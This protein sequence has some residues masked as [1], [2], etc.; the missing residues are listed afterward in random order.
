MSKIQP[1]SDSDQAAGAIVGG[2]LG[3]MAGKAIEE[4]ATTD[5]G[6]EFLVKL[7]NGAIKAFVEE[8]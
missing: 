2:L 6:F 7:S 4:N 5:T 1:I 3:A 8:F